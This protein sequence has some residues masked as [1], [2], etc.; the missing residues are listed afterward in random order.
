MLIE[1]F[2]GT[3]GG[4]EVVREQQENISVT[5]GQNKLIFSLYLGIDVIADRHQA[6]ASRY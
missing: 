5:P 2:L 6:F 1:K 4:T 3:L